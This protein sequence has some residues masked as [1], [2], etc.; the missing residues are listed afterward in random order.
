[1]YQ[2]ET[3]LI[4]LSSQHHDNTCMGEEKYHKT[5]IMMQYNATK[6]VVDVLDQLVREHTCT[7]STR[8]WPL[9]LF[10]NLI[11]VAC[12]K[13]FVLWMLQYCNWQQRRI[14]RRLYPLSLGEEMVTPRVRRRADSGNVDRHTC[15]VMTAMGTA[16]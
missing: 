8:C 7:R 3:R 16:Y 5:E 4:L 12:V 1:M 15:R 13:A 10:L 14:I 9:I 6:S 2:Q 11:D